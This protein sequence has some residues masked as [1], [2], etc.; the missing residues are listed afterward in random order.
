MIHV[1]KA[2]KNVSIRT[3]FIHMGI[4]TI[5]CVCVCE[6]NCFPL[7]VCVVVTLRAPLLS[8]SRERSTGLI[9]AVSRCRTVCRRAELG[10]GAALLK[11]PGF[12][13]CHFEQKKTGRHQRS[14]ASIKTHK[15]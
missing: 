3:L 4:K 9:P 2:Y 15:S 14:D 10:G 1:L 12:I 11:L 7:K 6:L 8:H 13:L 5:V